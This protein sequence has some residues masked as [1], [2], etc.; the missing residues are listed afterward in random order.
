MAMEN[1]LY[2]VEFPKKTSISKRGCTHIIP[3]FPRFFPL[4][5]PFIGDFGIFK[6]AM[7][8]DTE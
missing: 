4:K 2:T 3:Q 6:R 8:D 5:H 1:P 7:F